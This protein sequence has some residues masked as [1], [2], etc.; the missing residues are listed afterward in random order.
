LDPNRFSDET[1][2]LAIVP[3]GWPVWFAGRGNRNDEVFFETE[4]EARAEL[5]LRV[6]SD[7]TIRRR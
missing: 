3:G 7:P 2:C 6:V 4:D 5:L 1:Y